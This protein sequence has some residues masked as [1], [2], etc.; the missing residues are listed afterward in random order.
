MFTAIFNLFG[1][2]KGSSFFWKIIRNFFTLKN[3]FEAISATI[4]G[5]MKS[6][7]EM[8]TAPEMQVILKA[9]SN[10]MKTGIIILPGVDDYE[11]AAFIDKV[12]G[13]LE[14]SLSDSL[15]HAKAS[16]QIDTKNKDVKHV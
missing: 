4:D 13:E 16:F 11:V 5:I 7:R 8:P 6:D 15:T 14:I 1:L 12:S 3:S 2:I 9:F 10:I